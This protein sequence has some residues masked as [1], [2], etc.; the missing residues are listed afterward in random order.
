MTLDTGSSTTAG[1]G[2]DVPEELRHSILLARLDDLINWSRSNS[3][4]PMFF[5]L[6]C[7]FVEMATSL[8]ARHDIAR[9]GAEVIRG[10]PRQADLMVV[11][12]TV[13][14]KMAGPILRL[15]E[16]M[17]EPRW[18]ISMGS[19]SNSGGMYDVY[20]VVQGVDTLMPVDVYVQGCPPRPESLIEAL[21]LLQRKIRRE[22]HPALEIV[23]RREGVV[24]TTRAPRVQGVT[25]T[26][27]PRGPGFEGTG[28]RGTILRPGSTVPAAY[29]PPWNPPSPVAPN[30]R[31]LEQVEPALFA[32]VGT[33]P[34]DPGPTDTLT[35]RVRPEQLVPAMRFLAEEAEPRFRRLEFLCGIDNRPR[36]AGFRTVYHLAA[37]EPGK[38]QV[39]LVADLDA[40]HPR[41]PS[42]TGVFPAADWYE[43]ETFDMFGVRFDG[44]PDLRRIFMPPCW[45]G[46][47]LRKDHVA[48][49]SDLPPFTAADALEWERSIEEGTRLKP[50]QGRI[51]LNMG[52]HHP[53]THGVV[54]LVIELEGETIADMDPDVGY[55]HRG[56]E[57]IAERQ[58]WHRFIPYTDRVDYLAGVAN[59]LPYCLA[60]EKLLG[61]EVPPRGQVIRVMTGEL[62]RIASHLVWAGTYAQDLGAG[63]PVFYTFESREQILDFISKVTGGRMHPNWFR[64]G[65]VAEDLPAGWREDMESWLE[66]FPRQLAEVDKLLTG[67]PIFVARARGTG[68]IGKDEAIERGFSGPNLRAAG[69]AWDLRKAAPYSGYERYEFDVPTGTS[70][71]NYDRYLV[72][73]EEMRQSWRIIGQCVRDMPDGPWTSQDFRYSLPEQNRQ[74]HDIESLIH[75]FVN[76]SRGFVPAPGEAYVATEGPKGEYGYYAISNGSNLPYRVFIRTASFPHLQALPRLVRGEKVADL[77]ATLGG[78]DFVLGDVDK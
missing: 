33:L 42:V 43:R 1:R 70:G 78:I 40:H 9:F 47:P 13:F 17:L 41:V 55:H 45:Q 30:L 2:D 75:H 32:T 71:D 46:F 57:K 4:W 38:P 11:A 23:R 24:G 58:T 14:K 69:L 65:G 53:G 36:G 12:G 10:S 51:V 54:R 20:S 18:V 5:G 67:N 61:V 16:Q 22:E 68:P 19:C 60:V 6:S 37:L 31:G 64:I 7:C 52:P 66:R 35:W 77:I 3:L 62:F 56:P 44:H 73:M 29:F 59:N 25:T 76:V 21:I 8:T 28:S 63:T 50:E 39:R 49:G 26:Y 34:R 72:H 74:L 27:D 15:Y 48:R